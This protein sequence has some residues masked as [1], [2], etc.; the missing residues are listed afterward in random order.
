MTG[1]GAG[2][3]VASALLVGLAL[4]ALAGLVS[5]AFGNVA[6]AIAEFVL[7][8]VGAVVGAILLRRLR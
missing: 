1:A 7:L 4:I 2:Q 8:L 3:R 5:L 6:A